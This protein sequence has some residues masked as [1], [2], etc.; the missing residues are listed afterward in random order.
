MKKN[1]EIVSK[2]AKKLKERYCCRGHKR[3]RAKRPKAECER[4]CRSFKGH[5]LKEAKFLQKFDRGHKSHQ[6]GQSEARGW[7]H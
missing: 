4:G 1:P 7:D 6:K 2:K 3:Y 5:Q